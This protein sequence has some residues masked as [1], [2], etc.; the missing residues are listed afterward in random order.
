MGVDLST[1]PPHLS[2]SLS[3]ASPLS[4]PPTPP[5]LLIRPVVIDKPVTD[6]ADQ[7]QQARCVVG[8]FVRL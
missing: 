2:L 6:T 4:L 7:K 1:A 5:S 8:L 3:G